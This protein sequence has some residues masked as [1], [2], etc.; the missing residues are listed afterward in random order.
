M[1]SQNIIINC[2]GDCLVIYVNEIDDNSC[3]LILIYVVFGTSDKIKA[4]CCRNFQL[5]YEKKDNYF[6]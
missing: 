1:S 5:L 3:R 2:V 6:S 4:R